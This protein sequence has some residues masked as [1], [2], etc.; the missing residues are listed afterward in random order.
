MAFLDFLF[1]AGE[2][3]A[4]RQE[5]NASF[6]DSIPLESPWADNSHLETIT[7]ASLYG[8]TPDTLPVNRTSAMQ[9]ATVAKGRNLI[10]TSI[11]RMPLRATRNGALATNQPTVLTQLEVGTPN[12]ITLSWTVDSMLFHGRAF[13]LITEKGFDGRPLHIKYVPESQVETKDG[14]LVKAF[15]KAVTPADFIRLDANSEGFLSYGAGVI[16]EAQEIELAAR[17]AGASPVPSIVLKAKEG[18]DLT[19]DEIS[20]LLAGWTANR[21]KRGGSVAYANKAVDPVAMGQ[22]AENLLIDARNYAALQVARALSLPAWAV[23]ATVAGASLNYSNQASRNRELI[24]A[25]TGFMTSIEQTLSLFLPSGT[26]VKFDTAELLKGDTKDR[27]DAYAVALA[28]GF[29]TKDEVRARE[30]LDPLPVEEQVA[31]EIPVERP[32][33]S[34]EESPNE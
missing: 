14:Q 25:L 17:E 1:G 28:A 4:A 33:P 18:T 5:L 31:P 19:Q 7:L 2:N 13:W 9:I 12:F 6:I 32:A 27:Y 20:A 16:R 26:E 10:V 21:R 24:D 15:G 34:E 3:L 30:N 22:H 8:L 29:L 23:D 11:A